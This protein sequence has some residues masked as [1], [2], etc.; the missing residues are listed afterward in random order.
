FGRE[1]APAGILLKPAG[2]CAE[3]RGGGWGTSRQ[4]L[5]GSRIRK[6]IRTNRATSPAS[7]EQEPKIFLVNSLS[8]YSDPVNVVTKE[9]QDR[10]I[11]ATPL[12]GLC[13]PWRRS[14][15]QPLRWC[16]WSCRSARVRSVKSPKSCPCARRLP[17][18]L[19]S[20]KPFAGRY[21]LPSLLPWP[22]I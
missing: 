6:E 16:P 1:K 10:T 9:G 17:A 11:K 2:G 13:R 4:S 22:R 7:G 12:A 18:R 14:E 5:H 15:L 19:R 8:S 20:A 21:S 3:R